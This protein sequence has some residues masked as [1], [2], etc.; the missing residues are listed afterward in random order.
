MRKIHP[1]FIAL[2]VL[3]GPSGLILA[4]QKASDYFSQPDAAASGPLRVFQEIY[5]TCSKPPRLQRTVQCDEYVRYFERCLRPGSPCD[6]RTSY[7]VLTKLD[8]MPVPR[9]PPTIDKAAATGDPQVDSG[10]HPGDA[11]P[12]HDT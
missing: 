10:L 6:A 11:I 5:A 1:G 4:H 2:A 8:L 3:L 12:S 7:E 9:Q